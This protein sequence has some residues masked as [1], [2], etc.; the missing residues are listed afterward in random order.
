[1]NTARDNRRRP[2][3]T[4]ADIAEE[5]RCHPN[6]VRRLIRTGAWTAVKPGKAWLTAPAEL[7]RFLASAPRNH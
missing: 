2:F 4:V 6:E 3:L 1:M 5:L 7:D